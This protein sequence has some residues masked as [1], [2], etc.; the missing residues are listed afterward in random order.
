MALFGIRLEETDTTIPHGDLPEI[1]EVQEF[2]RFILEP[3]RFPAISAIW[4][5]LRSTKWFATQFAIPSEIKTLPRETII[6]VASNMI[7]WSN[8]LL[9]HCTHLSKALTIAEMR[10]VLA[11]V[12]TNLREIRLLG[13][14]LLKLHDASEADIDETTRTKITAW[15]AT[16]LGPSTPMI[17]QA[18]AMIFAFGIGQASVYV[19]LQRYWESIYKV[20]FGDAQQYM[21]MFILIDRYSV[22]T[23]HRLSTAYLESMERDTRQTQVSQIHEKGIG[24]FIDLHIKPWIGS[25]EALALKSPTVLQSASIAT[26]TETQKKAEG[27]VLDADV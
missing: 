10:L 14:R 20:V 27:L 2:D 5:L 26:A 23:H 4:K 16:Y 25:A 1:Y 19:F 18:K 12:L 21:L 11:A 13:I 6:G 9:K 7:V 8:A 24:L 22:N 15:C 3:A 17:L